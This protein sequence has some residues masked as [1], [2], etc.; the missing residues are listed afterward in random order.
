MARKGGT[1]ENLI[2]FKKGPDE[3][4]NTTGLNAGQKSLKMI[5]D[6]L[7][8]QEISIEDLNGVVIKV[9]A[10]EAIALNIISVAIKEED[11][12]VMLKAAKQAFEHTDPIVKEVNQTLDLNVT[13]QS[14]LSPEQA[15]QILKITRGNG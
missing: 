4:R 14:E 2:P 7:L 12:N 3:R 1:P 9:T 10:K 11:P 8:A 13:G 15:E 5:F 6:K